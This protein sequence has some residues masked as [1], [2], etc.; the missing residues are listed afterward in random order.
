MLALVPG[1]LGPL[2]C[3][4]L[5]ECVALSTSLGNGLQQS[6]AAVSW[7]SLIIGQG[8]WFLFRILPCR[9]AFFAGDLYWSFHDLLLCV[10]ST[11]WLN[12]LVLIGCSRELAC[13]P[14]GCIW[15]LALG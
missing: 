13:L 8:D 1:N 10:E 11:P 12:R 9:R 3:R 6:L 2:H 4:I 5:Q 14:L 15:V 7:A